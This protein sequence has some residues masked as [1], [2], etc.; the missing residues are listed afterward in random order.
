MGERRT[1]RIAVANEKG[2]VGKTATVVNLAAALALED[3]F[4]LVV[5]MDPQ[6]NSTLGLGVSDED[7]GVNVYDLIQSPGAIRAADAIRPTRWKGLELLPAVTDLAGAEVELV[8]VAGRENRLMEA[9]SGI[10]G[11]Y[12]FILL[13]TP[14]SLS[15]LTVNVFAFADEVLV[16]CQTQPYAYRALAELFDTVDLVSQAINPQLEVTGVVATFFDRRTRVSQNIFDRLS[17]DG[18]YGPL[19]FKTVIRANTTIAESADAGRPVVHFRRGSFGASDYR[20]LADE[21]IEKVP[22]RATTD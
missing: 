18:Q 16:P 2:G 14:P 12:D 21:L 1:R 9:L 20:Q 5:D 11:N 13:D 8:E 15:L 17:S 7:V 4:V 6:H 22:G 19:L 10:D 3:R